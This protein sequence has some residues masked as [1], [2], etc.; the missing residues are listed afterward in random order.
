MTDIPMHV[1]PFEHGILRIWAFDGASETGRALVEA[2][3]Q[4]P[5]NAGPAMAALGAKRV[6]PYWLDLVAMR[7]IAE[8]GLNGYLR[9]AYDVSKEDLEAAHLQTAHDHVLIAPSRAFADHEQ[10]LSPDAALTALGSLDIHKD[11]G[12]LRPMEPVETARREPA[13]PDP[14]EP[15]PGAPAGR[16]LRPG[17][18]LL[19]LLIAAAFIAIVAF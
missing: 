8:L 15:R 3:R 12:A 16:S 19:L 5:R 10:T 7:D 14:E 11:V 17:A 6:D 2:M 1:T 13:S 4:E 9:Q 18:I